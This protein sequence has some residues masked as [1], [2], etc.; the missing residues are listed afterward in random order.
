M[1]NGNCSPQI[2][3][4]PGSFD[5]QIADTTE[6]HFRELMVWRKMKY[7]TLKKILK[8]KDSGW[9][10]HNIFRLGFSRYLFLNFRFFHFFAE[11]WHNCRG[12]VWCLR[13]Y[14]DCVSLILFLW[15]WHLILNFLM[16]LV[17]HAY[18]RWIRIILV[19]FA[20]LFLNHSFKCVYFI[21][22]Q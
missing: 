6:L 7:S 8:K 19:N 20:L 4:S 17:K 21:L 22:S 18:K 12:A 2:W 1:G 9:Y 5:Q 16:F 3:I 14:E 11:V 13:C 10:I 15:R